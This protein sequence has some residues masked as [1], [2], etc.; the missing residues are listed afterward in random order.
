MSIDLWLEL[1]I[2]FKMERAW[3]YEA[4]RIGPTFFIELAKFIEAATIHA[5]SKKTKEI[6]Y[7]CHDCKNQLLWENPKTIR[8][9]LLRRGFVDNYKI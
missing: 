5:A 4:S 3:M 9:H 8:S 2:F 7:P 6:L 1:M